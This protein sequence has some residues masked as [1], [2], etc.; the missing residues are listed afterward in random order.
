VVGTLGGSTYGVT[1]GVSLHSVRVL[2]C[3]GSGTFFG[4][5]SG[6]EWVTA[7]HIKPAVANMSLGGG[8]NS[9][10]DDSVQAFIKTGVVYVVAAGN[11]NTSACNYSPARAPNTLTAG[12]TTNGDARASYSNYDSCLDLFAPGSDIT[13]AVLSG[14]S[15]ASPHMAGAVALH[16]QFNPPTLRAPSAPR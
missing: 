16:L 13:S 9:A 15:M 12:T 2:D 11:N 10:L 4:V 6:L 7:H 1:K 8:A 5:I 3:G 14:T